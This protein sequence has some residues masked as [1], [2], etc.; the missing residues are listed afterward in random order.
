MKLLAA[1][2]AIISRRV[3]PDF[4]GYDEL[5]PFIESADAS[6]FNLETT[7]N[8]E[9]ECPSAELSGGTYI[10]TTPKVLS[11]LEALGFNMTTF[12]NNHAL[13]FPLRDFFQRL[14]RL[15]TRISYTQEQE[16][17]SAR[18]Q[19]RNTLKPMREESL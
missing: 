2:D 9:G 14:R 3:Q 19:S 1:G 12:N 13:I 5:R 6:S 8:E 18:R 17:R 15:R 10:R 4:K 7:L 11:D 16:E